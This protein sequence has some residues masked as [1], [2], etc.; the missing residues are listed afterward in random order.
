M[1][2]AAKEFKYVIE[3]MM[4]PLLCMV[5]QNARGLLLI[6]NNVTLDSNVVSV[7]CDFRST[8]RCYAYFFLVK[9]FFITL[10]RKP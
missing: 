6:F 3:K 1:L 5:D 10:N 4:T 2:P 8:F 9:V 7:V